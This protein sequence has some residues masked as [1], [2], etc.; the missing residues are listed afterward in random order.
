MVLSRRPGQVFVQAEDVAFGIG[1]P[2]G[3]L[4]SQ[5]ADVLDGLKTRQVVVGK[6]NA[7][8]LQRGDRYVNVLDP[9]ANGRVLG[10]GLNVSREESDLGSA[11]AIHDLPIRLFHPGRERKLVLLEPR[12][13]SMSF[14]GSKTVTWQVSRS[15]STS[16]SRI[17]PQN[18][19]IHELSPRGSR[20]CG[21]DRW[22]SGNRC[23]SHSTGPP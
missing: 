6:D 5:N 15:T 1:E 7:A 16:T 22:L 23:C 9:K 3:L 2:R 19:N 14:T 8:G 13:R 18:S 21:I 4:E 12:A 10:L 17:G 20:H 11:A